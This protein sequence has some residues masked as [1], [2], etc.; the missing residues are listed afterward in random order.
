MRVLTAVRKSWLSAFRTFRSG[1]SY[2]PRCL[3]RQPAFERLA[4]LVKLLGPFNHKWRN[5]GAPM[6][7]DGD[8]A[9]SL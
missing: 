4:Q 7:L 1:R 5:D 3:S 8:V 9:L 6:S 2:P